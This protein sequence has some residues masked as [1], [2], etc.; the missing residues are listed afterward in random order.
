[1]REHVDRVGRHKNDPV[2]IGRSDPGHDLG[3]D[4]GVALGEVQPS[5]PGP[6][7]G[8]C[9]KDR[10]DRAGA[11]LVVARPDLGRAGEGNGMGKVH[12]LA[13][14]PLPVDIDEDNLGS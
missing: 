14:R 2:R 3:E 11:V 7:A 8:P 9:C 5:L 13:F 12:R 4:R 10:D 1:M 6:L